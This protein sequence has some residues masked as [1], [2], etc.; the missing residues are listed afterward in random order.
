MNIKNTLIN[1]GIYLVIEVINNALKDNIPENLEGI[2][3]FSK[4]LIHV[5]IISNIIDDNIF[6]LDK[7]R[8]NI[9]SFFIVNKIITILEENNEL[10]DTWK[11]ILSFIKKIWKIWSLAD[12]IDKYFFDITKYKK[13]RAHVINPS[14]LRNLKPLLQHEITSVTSPFIITDSVEIDTTQ[15]LNYNSYHVTIDYNFHFDDGALYTKRHAVFDFDKISSMLNHQAA[16]NKIQ[17]LIANNGY[18][19]IWVNTEDPN[20]SRIIK[21]TTST[22]GIFIVFSIIYLIFESVKHCSKRENWGKSECIYHPRFTVNI[23]ES[24]VNL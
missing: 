7:I 2:I 15:Q 5:F 1:I 21:P 18:F 8:M 14:D 19:D 10:D 11:K 6:N 3:N 12:I 23:K 9:F 13:F 24:S 16:Q 4:L 17:E 22:F 20:D